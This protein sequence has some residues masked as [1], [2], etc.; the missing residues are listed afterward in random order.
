MEHAMSELDQSSPLS[1]IIIGI[2]ML[3][4]V[5]WMYS[6]FNNLEATGGSV[7]MPAIAVILYKIFG[8]WALVGLVGFVGFFCTLLGFRKLIKS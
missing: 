2:L 4:G 6:A 5:W 1:L 3:A 7:S 8:K